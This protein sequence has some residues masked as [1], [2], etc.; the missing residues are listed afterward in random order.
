MFILAFPFFMFKLG[1]G[2]L[3]RTGYTQLGNQV[4]KYIIEQSVIY[5][6]GTQKSILYTGILVVCFFTITP[7]PLSVSVKFLERNP[8]SSD[9]L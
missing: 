1:A 5:G 8:F 7:L 4:W 6:D 2:E 3:V 9:H